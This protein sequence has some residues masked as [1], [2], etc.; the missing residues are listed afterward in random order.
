LVRQNY[1]YEKRQRDLAK[2]KKQ[3]EKRQNKLD[4]KKAPADADSPPDEETGSPDA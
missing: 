1:K 2:K 4:R 3:E